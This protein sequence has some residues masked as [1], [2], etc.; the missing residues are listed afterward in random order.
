MPTQKPSA[1]P[2]TH[3]RCIETLIDEP[4]DKGHIAMHFMLECDAGRF[5][6]SVTGPMSMNGEMFVQALL[7]AKA[8]I[9]AAASGAFDKDKRPGA[10]PH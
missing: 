10:H 8:R 6:V 2:Q 1:K 7:C 5:V 9:V 3:W 4:D